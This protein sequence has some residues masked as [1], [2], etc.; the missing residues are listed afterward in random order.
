MRH[1]LIISHAPSPNTQRLQTALL[2][3]ADHPDLD[4]TLRC[5]SPFDAAP[6][7]VLDAA[8]VLL[9]TPENFGYM[10]GAMKD[11]FDRCYMPLLEQTQGLSCAALVRAGMDGTGTC[12]ALK[13][14]TSGL[15]WRWIQEPKV[16]QGEWQDHW[17]EEATELALT[18]AAGL[19]AGLY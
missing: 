17:P 4:L 12:R 9:F 10:S 16:L 13:S 18:F 6:Q 2:A 11:F 19:E 5:L 15:K 1:L 3:A 14:I 8:G 7:D